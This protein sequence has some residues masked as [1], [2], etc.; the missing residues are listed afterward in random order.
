MKKILFLI[1]GVCTLNSCSDYY[2]GDER[3]VIEGF[4]VTQGKPFGN[5]T[6]K[7]Y[8]SFHEPENGTISEINRNDEYNHDGW[9]FYDPISVTSTNTDGKISL[10]IPRSEDTDVFVIEIGHDYDTKTYGYISSYNTVNHY[11]N[12]GTLTY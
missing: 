12:L 11:V 3:I 2:D 10:S 7:V 8:P 1:I 5:V 6:I 4:V 9:K